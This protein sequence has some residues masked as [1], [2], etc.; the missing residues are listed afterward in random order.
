[1]RAKLS[2]IILQV[3]AGDLS[4]FSTLVDEHKNLVYSI[5]LKMV[6]KPEEA[7]EVVQDTFVKAFK[8]IRQYRG[9]SKF[10]TWLYKI[11][12]FTAINHLRKQKSLSSPLDLVELETD[13]KSALETLKEE[14]RK[15]YVE[16]AMSYLRPL[17][18][19]L[20]TFFYWDDLSIK[21][22]SQITLLSEANIKVKLVRI[23]KQMNG[24]LKKLLRNELENILS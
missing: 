6:R 21:E 4:S 17:D 9:D 14:N 13:D 19:A 11:A 12:Y 1:M 7:E 23:R 10:S 5:V 16:K 2:P 22:I 20:I 15:Q 24:I 3:Q 18:R 8:S